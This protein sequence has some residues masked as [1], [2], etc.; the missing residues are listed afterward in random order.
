MKFFYQCYVPSVQLGYKL[1]NNVGTLCIKS[2]SIN[3]VHKSWRNRNK[4]ARL[5]GKCSVIRPL[6]E[7][8]LEAK[9]P[10]ARIG[11]SAFLYR[12]R[13]GRVHVKSRWD[14]AEVHSHLTLS[15][16]PNLLM[17]MHFRGFSKLVSFSRELATCLVSLL[18]PSP[19]VYAWGLFS[20]PF[21]K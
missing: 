19:A 8:H 9:S 12:R 7:R 4:N 21:C 6:K 5:G 2:R 15:G 3:L 20:S 11:I 1:L 10:S 18:R 16:C 13:P 14:M 17:N